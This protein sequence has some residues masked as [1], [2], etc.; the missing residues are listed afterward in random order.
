MSTRLVL[1]FPVLAFATHAGA[2]ERL[3]FNRDIRPILT[4]NCYACHGLDS[5]HR[6]ADLWLDVR[7]GALQDGAIG[8]GKP[9]ASEVIALCVSQWKRPPRSVQY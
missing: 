3:Q 5:S 7:E 4:A 9:E 6:K 2:L 1:F 8:P